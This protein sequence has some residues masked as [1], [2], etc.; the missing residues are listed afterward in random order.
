MRDSDRL[1]L[2]GFDQLPG[3]AHVRMP[4]VAALFAISPATVWRWC[5]CGRLPRPQRIMGV[6]YWTVQELRVCLQARRELAADTARNTVEAPDAG[7]ACR[8]QTGTSGD[9]GDQP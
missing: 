3:S 7:A 1:A 2:Q 8:N 4:V 6:T 5:K 9:E